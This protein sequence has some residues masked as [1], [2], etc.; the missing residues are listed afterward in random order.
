MSKKHPMTLE[1]CL[2]TL[3]A[4]KSCIIDVVELFRLAS[5]NGDPNTFEA[6]DLERLAYGTRGKKRRAKIKPANVGY[7]RPNEAAKF[8][9]VSVQSLYRWA[10]RGEFPKPTKLGPRCSGWKISELQEWLNANDEGA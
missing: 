3:E 10:S 9:G 7:L 5:Q 4:V 8:V 1:E 6:I 2:D